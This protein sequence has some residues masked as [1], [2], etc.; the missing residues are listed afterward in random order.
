MLALENA[1]LADL[2]NGNLLPGHHIAVEGDLIVEVSDRPIKS[3]DAE[4][5]D[6]AGRC[7]L[8]GLIDA[9]FH[10]T[11]TEMNPANSRDLP[12]TLMTAR[13]GVL[14][15]RALM[16]GYTTVRD[17]A[18]ADWGMRAAT[19]EGTI[20]GPRLYIAGRA[21]SQTG[22]HGDLRRRADQEIPCSCSNALAFMSVVA[23]GTPAV[24]AAAREQLRQG[25]DHLK[26]FVSGGVVS[27]SDPLHSVQYTGEELS[28]IVHEAASWG[29]Y[30]AAHA[31]TPPS[32]IRAVTAGIRTIEHGNLLD[33]QA[34]AAMA[35]SKAF[36]V[37]TLITYDVMHRKGSTIG[38]SAFSLEKLA[39]VFAAGLR[40]IELAIKAGVCVGF[41]TDLLGEL[42]EHQSEELLLRARIQKPH[43][44]L[45]AATEINA[46][47][48]G[49][50]GKL[51]AIRP[52][53]YAD[54]IAVKG[55]PL[56][57]LGLLQD[58]GAHLDLIMK[59]GAVVKRAL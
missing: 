51:G 21:L 13:A 22:G 19:A 45:R 15:R 7:L 1:T 20:L 29:T 56:R 32:I 26:V 55:D 14:L 44:V 25:V 28:A 31:Y 43:E 42:H 30:V 23:D 5:I 8:P 50:S 27:P 12:P 6:L 18:G 52:G 9:H 38:L 59:A 16:R 35:T 33:A 53:A 57:D 54:L 10:A 46:E 41:G 49:L 17:M 2:T 40:S 24:Q 3:A 48:L 36:L 47:I 58:Q 37:P 39:E 11:L 34:A 4:R